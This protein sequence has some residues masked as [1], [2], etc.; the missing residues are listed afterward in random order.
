[1]RSSA[2]RLKGVRGRR[3]GFTVI[4][5]LLVMVISGIAMAMAMPKLAAVRDR[6]ALRGAR[7]QV[8]SYVTMARG[9]AVRRRLPAQVRFSSNTAWI[10]VTQ[11]NG[12]NTALGGTIQLASDHKV[13]MTTSVTNINFDQRGIASNLVGTTILRFTRNG[14]KDSL[15]VNRLGLI[16]K[17]CGA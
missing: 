16:S 3:P 8:S 11:T 4:E 14:L 12:T 13:T 7:Q 1:M 2:R 5:L 17:R 9:A 15:C 6:S 10:T